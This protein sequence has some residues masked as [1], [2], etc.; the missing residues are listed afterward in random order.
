MNKLKKVWNLFSTFNKFY[1]I[2]LGINL[3][4]GNLAI[5]AIMILVFIF[6]ERETI[7]QADDILKSREE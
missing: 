3:L 7:K 1:L 2:V 4:I 6:T 5:S